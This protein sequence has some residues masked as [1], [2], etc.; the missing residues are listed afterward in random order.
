MK[1]TGA[2]ANYE[3]LVDCAVRVP[4]RSGITLGAS[5]TR[6]RAEGRFPA[7]IWYDPYRAAWDGSVGPAA[8]YFAERVGCR[9]GDCF[10]QLEELNVF[11]L[12]KILR[13]EEL[14]QTNNL[15]A[16]LCRFADAGDRFFEIDVRL[17]LTAH[18]DQADLNDA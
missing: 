1:R 15:R 14:L 9:P 2:A 16:F 13:A 5:L 7:L 17:G 11:R 10:R 6:P 12:T 3:T 8:R 18:L 4:T